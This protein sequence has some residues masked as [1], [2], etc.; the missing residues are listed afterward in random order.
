MPSKKR[1]A[2]SVIQA[3]GGLLWRGEGRKEIA[4][5]HRP[6][7]D[8]WSLPKGKLHKGETWEQAAIRDVEE[9]TNCKASLVDFAGCSC[10]LFAGM[11]KVVL[12]WNM[13]LVHERRFEPHD[14]V[15][16]L[17][18][19]PLEAAIVKLSYGAERALLKTEM[20]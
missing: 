4:V 13:E 18:W 2:S 8:D 15:D 12:Y 11:P 20:S 16:Q 10:Y 3:A 1:H 5:I 7:Y 14:E 6:R 17:V 9:E 19:L